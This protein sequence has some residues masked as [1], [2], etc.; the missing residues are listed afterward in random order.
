MEHNES[1]GRRKTHSYKCLQKETGVR[2]H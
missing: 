1:S 2:L